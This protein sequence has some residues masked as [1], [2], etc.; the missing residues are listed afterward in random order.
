[1]AAVAKAS[2]GLIPQPFVIRVSLVNKKEQSITKKA[3][4]DGP[5][6]LISSV[7]KRLSSPDVPL[8][9]AFAYIHKYN[10]DYCYN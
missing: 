7:V 4:R 1:M 6:S 8:T 3:L 2:S 10:R 5:K 9:Y